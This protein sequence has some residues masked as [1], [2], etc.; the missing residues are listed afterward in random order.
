MHMSAVIGS[1]AMLMDWE[2]ERTPESDEIQII[3]TLFPKVRSTSGL[4]ALPAYI[5]R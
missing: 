5:A 4:A 1:A 2:H 3:A